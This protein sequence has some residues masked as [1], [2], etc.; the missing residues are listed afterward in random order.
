MRRYSI[1]SIL[2]HWTMA[3]AIGGAGIVGSLLEDMP[4]GPGKASALGAHML[5]GLAVAA[6]LLPRI[7][8]RLSGGAPDGPAP[9]WEKRLAAAAHLL[10]YALMLAVP[11]T[12]LAIA[13][14]ARAPT[15]VAGLFAIPNPLAPYGLR[16][17]LE[18][19]HDA[20]ANLM[21]GAVALHVAATLWHVLVRRDG[22]AA[23]M[24]PRGAR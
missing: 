11:L 14:S 17:T 21:L 16:R 19:V 6:L 3:A 4:R 9:G 7:L 18:A 23:R 1:P 22:V 24:L 10:L 5:L 2:L 12:G 20:M 15:D 8:A 13:M